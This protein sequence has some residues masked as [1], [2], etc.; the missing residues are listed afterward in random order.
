MMLKHITS[1]ILF[2]SLLSVAD[3]N[4][5]Q[6]LGLT[7]E[8]LPPFE[9]KEIAEYMDKILFQMD[10]FHAD[11]SIQ[12]IGEAL[13]LIDPQKDKEELY[14][15]LSYR[16]EVL[17][18]EGLF[19][20][21]MRDL[22]KG[23]LI[24]EGLKDSLLIANIYNLKGLLYENIEESEG[25]LSQLSKAL[26]YYPKKPASRYPI[27]ELH[28]IFGNMGSYLTKIHIYDTA[29]VCLQ[30]SLEL[31]KR[32]HA[33]RAIAVAHFSLG[34]L[35]LKTNDPE[36]ALRY[37]DAALTAALD[38]TDYDVA[39]DAY[40]GKAEASL[41]QGD[42]LQAK[43]FISE[44][45]LH[46]GIYEQQIGMVTQRNHAKRTSQVFKQMN[47]L[48]GALFHLG[49]WRHFDS[50]IQ[51]RNVQSALTTQ[52]ALL[53]SNA[54]LELERLSLQ[55]KEEELENFKF[56]QRILI[57]VSAL[58]IF[59]L[60]FIY[61]SIRI[62]RRNEKRFAELEVS[63][64]QQEKIIAELQIRE[65]VGRD[66]HDDLGAGLSALKLKS[67]M[68]IRTEQ[69]PEKKVQLKTIA[70]TAGELI[71]SMRQIIWSMNIDQTNLEDLIV[72]TSSHARRY[73]E[74][75]NLNLNLQLENQWP[76][77]ELSAQQRR[78]IFLMVKEALHNIV[79]H[80]KADH[81]MMSIRWD[82]A[83]V[84]AI[85]DNGV[86]IT[87]SR[88]NAGNGM[89]NMTRRAEDLRGSIEFSSPKGVL[90]KIRIPFDT[91]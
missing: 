56:N 91:N 34:E 21:A 33:P 32:A 69:D 23:L 78:N 53:Q 1:F 54:N 48:N 57:G 44:S 11:T 13:Q 43:K 7:I 4:A 5:Q 61:Q 31:A 64:L 89:K 15:L 65:Q 16:A 17:Y 42:F 81:V 26:E 71:D 40:V 35:A 10:A 82:N 87:D 29:Y 63:R 30:Q 2:F 68:A 73:M 25:S 83:L 58:V 66:M 47:D 20:E 41:A 22:D 6:T 52:A 75:N 76:S 24:A 27:S 86:G 72:Y 14:Y 37:F 39:L 88:S 3:V 45:N 67:E 38:A 55:Q 74:E 85:E 62:R 18:Y 80:S 28:H 79:K 36:S 90:L 46:L 50:L 59:F 77:I 49:Q 51:S 60:L 9:N 19:N 12:Y 8:K 84:I 70:N